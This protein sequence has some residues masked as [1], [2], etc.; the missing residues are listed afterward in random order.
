MLTEWTWA[1]G[2]CAQIRV[3]K[4]GN[5][6]GLTRRVEKIAQGSGTSVKE[7]EE[8]VFLLLPVHLYLSSFR[9]PSVLA[10]R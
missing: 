7:V 8:F 4:E 5:P 9:F 1:D 6:I 10:L 2:V 3:D